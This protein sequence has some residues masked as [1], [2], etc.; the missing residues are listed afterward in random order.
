MDRYIDAYASEIKEFCQAVGENKPVS[1][2]GRDGL[3]S[4]AIALAAKRSLAEHRPVKVAEVL[5]DVK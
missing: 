5:R 4:V 1:V 3:M 2:G